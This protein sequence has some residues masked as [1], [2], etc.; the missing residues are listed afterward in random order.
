MYAPKPN[1]TTQLFNQSKKPVW[2]NRKN[3]NLKSTAQDHFKT[4]TNYKPEKLIIL[5]LPVSLICDLE[6]Q[7]VWWWVKVFKVVLLK[8]VIL[9][10]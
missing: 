6:K 5:L 1:Y 9:I 8:Q 10:I 7:E 2:Q 4:D 3:V